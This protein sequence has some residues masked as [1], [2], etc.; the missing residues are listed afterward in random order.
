MNCNK[1]QE[2]EIISEIVNQIVYD[3][4]GRRGLSLEDI[5]PDIFNKIVVEWESI[6]RHGLNKLKG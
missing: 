3:L 4:N 2:C 6:V 1:C 5:E